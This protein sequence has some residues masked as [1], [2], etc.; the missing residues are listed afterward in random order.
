MRL[1]LLTALSSVVLAL[2]ANTA[3]A[4]VVFEL[5][6]VGHPGNFGN[7]SGETVPVQGTVMGAGIDRICGAVSYPFEI[8]K[9]EVT[10]SQYVEFLNAVAAAD[11]Y[12]LYSTGASGTGGDA[13]ENNITRSG[14][15]G[16]FTYVV[17]DGSPAGLVHWGNRPI[18]NISWADA[19]RFC[20]WMENG[21][22]TGLLTG[23][24]AQDAWLTED[25]TYPTLG[26]P[27]VGSGVNLP[28]QSVVRRPGARWVIPS[29]DEWYKAAYHKNDGTTANYSSYP[30]NYSGSLWF[31][32]PNN[33]VIDPDPGNNANYHI[34]NPDDDCIGTPYYRSNVGE[35]ENSPSS[36]NTFDQGGNVWEWTD[37]RYITATGALSQR[38]VLRGG[39]YY[40][41]VV[42]QQPDG[43][44]CMHA[45][46]REEDPPVTGSGRHGFGSRASR[47]TAIT[48]GS[49]ISPSSRAEPAM[50]TTSTAFW[51][52]A[53][54]PRTRAW[55]AMRTVSWM[56]PKSAM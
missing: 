11:P 39:S 16:S 14:T 21:Q 9:F 38:R 37:T 20:N 54:S 19:A 23:V 44:K 46:W 50:I 32:T 28:Y 30:T 17:A 40:P 3:M 35:F 33:D 15:P 6:P 36:Y 52:V 53:T 47:T 49:R 41:S 25:G 45:A 10:I 2:C 24:G 55:T 4:E 22:P 18:V 8:A 51:T 31:G 27:T 34:G 12:N 42:Q 7:W 48:T 43:F 26:A 29:E 5:V 1:K 13:F 56:R